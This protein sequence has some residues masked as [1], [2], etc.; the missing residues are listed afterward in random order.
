VA[1][2]FQFDREHFLY[3]ALA[4]AALATAWLLATTVPD[5]YETPGDD[6]AG[7]ATGAPETPTSTRTTSATLYYVSE[8]GMQLVGLQREVPQADEPATQA[9]IIIEQLLASAP[10]PY[11]SAIPEGTRVNAVYLT[12]HGDVFVDL[13]GEAVI[14]HSGGSLEELFTVYAIVNAVTTNVPGA[15]GVQILIDG[16][17]VDT[18]AGHVDLRHP[19]SRNLKWVS[20]PEDEGVGA[21]R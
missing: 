6:D 10:S 14:E 9:R 1:S 4:V 2:R 3:G 19:L 18:L 16:R 13:S 11:L 12:R 21:R 5:L 8:D 7:T 15:L 20:A 17:E